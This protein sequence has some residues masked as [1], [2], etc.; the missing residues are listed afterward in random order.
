MASPHKVVRGDTLGAIA[1]ANNTTVE[2][3]MRLNPQIKNADKISIGWEVALPEDDG[4]DGAVDTKK[5]DYTDD[6]K[7][8]F[9][10][11]P[12]KPE[13]WKKGNTWYAVYFIPGTDPPLPIIYQVPTFDDVKSFFDKKTPLADRIVTD[14]DIKASGG[15]VMGST[16]NIPEEDGDPWAGFLARMD[17]AAET[18]PWLSD[19]EVFALH[20]SAWLEGRE[21]EQWE[22]EGTVWWQTQNK[23]QRDWAWTVMRDPEQAALRMEDRQH[24]VTE[25]LAGLGIVL[26]SRIVDYIAEQV[27]MGHWS[28]EKGVRQIQ[29]IAGGSNS[30]Y[31]LDADLAA[32]IEETGT[33]APTS[34]F[35]TQNVIDLYT[36]WLGP[37][38][39]QVDEAEAAKW[40]TRIRED[41]DVAREELVAHLKQSRLALF[42]EYTDES[43]S[44]QDIAAPWKNFATRIWGQTVDESSSMFLEILAANDAGKA[45]QILRREGLKED[46]TQVTQDMATD[47]LGPEGSLRRA[48]V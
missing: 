17:R 48:A 10:G 31:D 25:T 42:P 20:A 18:Q 14:A 2:E 30:S 19:P 5:T 43:M 3:L 23:R 21:V 40:A 29:A 46:V 38:M 22:L 37:A 7:T 16:D 47:A 8:R 4:G 32:F 24:A 39:G 12:G 36:E 26:D 28:E 6:A 34:T 11:L 1:K 41:G 15:L 27:E 13:I 44:Y 35:G 9:T 45:G 33:E